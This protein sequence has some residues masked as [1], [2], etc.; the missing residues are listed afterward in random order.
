MDPAAEP[1]WRPPAAAS[2]ASSAVTGQSNGRRRRQQPRTEPPPPSEDDSS[3]PVS[4]SGGGG[5]QDLID[6]E[7]KRFRAN[8]SSDDN[9]SFRTD[10]EGDSRNGSKVV[11]QNPPPPEPPKQDYIHVRARRGQATDSH[12]LAERARR[13]KIT[14]RMKILQDLVPGCNKV[15]GK[16]SVLDEII[17]YVQA[18]ERQ[19]EFL[20]MKLEAVNAHVNNGVETFPSKDVSCVE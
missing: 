10:A 8:K 6:S 11:D 1:S 15:I 12:S 20:S 2:G 7:A 17:N 18:L 4:T 16:A 3:R 13:E 9:G 14:E 19:V 5:S